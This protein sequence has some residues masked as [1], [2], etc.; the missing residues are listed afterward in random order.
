M[1]YA[2][3]SFNNTDPHVFEHETVVSSIGNKYFNF[4]PTN[5]YVFM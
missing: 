2:F 4:I 1:Q 5:I 3:G